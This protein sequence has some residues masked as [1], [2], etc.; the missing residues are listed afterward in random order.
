MKY[1]NQFSLADLLYTP[2][3]K[4]QGFELDQLVA[5]QL[6]SEDAMERDIALSLHAYYY[7]SSVQQKYKPIKFVYYT[8]VQTSSSFILKR[9]L[10]LSPRA[11]DYY[12]TDFKE[13]VATS[14]GLRD[15]V[16]SAGAFRNMMINKDSILGA[17][18][19]SLITPLIDSPFHKESSIYNYSK[20]L[21]MYVYDYFV[22]CEKPIKDDIYY[23]V[24]SKEYA[25]ATLYRDLEKSPRKL[26]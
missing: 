23:K 26:L 11:K 10:I 21:A 1:P 15:V 6:N 4:I 12:S 24:V 25:T 22:N 14:E 2:D 16:K 9:D 19:K 5:N 7:T 20:Q 3:L 17:D 8:L 13:S 18:L